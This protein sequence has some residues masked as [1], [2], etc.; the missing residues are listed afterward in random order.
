MKCL[1]SGEVNC[2]V[3]TNLKGY[4]EVA[5]LPDA[6]LNFAEFDFENMSFANVEYATVALR[7]KERGWLEK[8]V[9][10]YSDKYSS[11]FG[12][13]SIIYRFTVKGKI[14]H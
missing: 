5:S 7:E 11:P 12:I 13:Y 3:G 9:A 1:G 14:K 8:T 10:V 4:K 6:A 2:E